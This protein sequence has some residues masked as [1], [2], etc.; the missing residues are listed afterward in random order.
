MSSMSCSAH[1]FLLWRIN[2]DNFGRYVNKPSQPS[3]QAR[4]HVSYSHLQILLS[5]LSNS[6]VSRVQTKT[7]PVTVTFNKASH[8]K[9][10]PILPHLNQL[11]PRFIPHGF[12]CHL[13]PIHI[14]YHGPTISFMFHRRWIHIT[15]RR[16]IRRHCENRLS[17]R[18]RLH[19]T[20]SFK[21][22]S[23]SL[24]SHFDFF[25]SLSILK[26]NSTLPSHGS[27]TSTF[28]LF[29]ATLT[30]FLRISSPCSVL[31]TSG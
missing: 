31:F 1:L 24:L 11:G 3:V 28:Y 12:H 22:R 9:P 8:P 16:E 15:T 25:L 23:S 21:A 18:Q 4:T 5:H 29:P 27:N 13:V 7:P 17:R 26:N 30:K 6:Q 14:L 19:H 10:T 20:V 2:I